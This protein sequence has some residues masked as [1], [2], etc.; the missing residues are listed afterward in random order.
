SVIEK[1][2]TSH[3]HQQGQKLFRPFQVELSRA[4]AN[5]KVGEY[6]LTY[7]HG[8]QNT[9]EAIF[10]QAQPNGAAYFRLVFPNQFCRCLGIAASHALEQF[11]KRLFVK[12]HSASPYP[13]PESASRAL[14]GD[15]TTMKLRP[16]KHLAFLNCARGPSNCQSH[17]AQCEQN[18]PAL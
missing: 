10:T 14:A 17:T 6:R 8:V 18:C 16:A 3:G 5:K 1:P 12:H 9:A 7:V 4:G 15:K 13:L 2:V 11:A